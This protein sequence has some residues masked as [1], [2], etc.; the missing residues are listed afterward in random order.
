MKERYCIVGAGRSGSSLLAA[1]LA[2]AGAEF[3]LDQ[4]EIDREYGAYEHPR[5]QA[6]GRWLSRFEKIDSSLWPDWLGKDLCKRRVL[7]CLEAALSR[8]RFA[9]T[10]SLVK[11]LH[12][13]YQLDYAPKVIAA[14]RPFG[15]YS[16]SRYVRHGWSATRLIDEYAD[17]NLTAYFQVHVFGGCAIG[18][19]D[20]VNP[21]ASAW[22]DALAELTGIPRQALKTSRDKRLQARRY[23]PMGLELDPKPGEIYDKLTSLRGQVLPGVMGR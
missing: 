11:M 5:L 6:A 4:R 2:D 17:V 14:F 19:E 9:K 3:D 8:A 12:F 20:L 22:A 7:G 21:D 18:Y 23:E 15:D 13:V 10:T 1:I 16:R